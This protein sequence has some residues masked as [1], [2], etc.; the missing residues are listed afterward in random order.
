MSQSDEKLLPPGDRPGPLPDDLRPRVPLPHLP[1]KRSPTRVTLTLPRDVEEDLRR[2]AWMANRRQR[3]QGAD[4]DL[5]FEEFL[6][7]VLRHH[8]IKE[9]HTLKVLR[10]ILRSQTP[11]YGGSV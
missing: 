3:A 11:T 4:Q 2:L 6:V 9:D 5:T 1:L 8:L 10:R 7:E